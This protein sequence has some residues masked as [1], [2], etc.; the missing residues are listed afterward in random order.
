M[1]S[2]ELL[3]IFRSTDSKVIGVVK[4]VDERV[5]SVER[6]VEDVGDKVQ[7]IDDRVKDVHNDVQ[8]V[9]SK[10]QGVSEQVQD[11]NRSSSPHLPTFYSEGSTI[12]R[13][14]AKRQSSM[15][16]FTTRPIHES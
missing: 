2:A 14:P 8:G 6:K 10:V 1:A 3:K 7:G 12:L 11:V 9:E 13:E 5:G 15:V 4:G 16:V